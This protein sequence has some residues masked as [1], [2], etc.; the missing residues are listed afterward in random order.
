MC[1]DIIITRSNGR[2][3][4]PFAQSVTKHGSLER[5]ITSEYC[6]KFGFHGN[7]HPTFTP[8]EFLADW[9][10]TSR[11]TPA[12]ISAEMIAGLNSR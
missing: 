2:L 6:A 9:P 5:G 3:S 7:D 1:G 10:R 4:G 8:G 12:L 11:S